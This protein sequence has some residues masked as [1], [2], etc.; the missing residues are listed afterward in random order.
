[1]Y[2]YRYIYTYTRYFHIETKIQNALCTNAQSFW[3]INEKPCHLQVSDQGWKIRREGEKGGI[4]PFLFSLL[5]PPFPLHPPLPSICWCQGGVPR[6]YLWRTLVLYTLLCKHHLLHAANL[7][8]SAALD[9]LSDL[10]FLFASLSFSFLLLLLLPYYFSFSFPS[11]SFFLLFLFISR[12]YQQ[13]SWHSFS[14]C[15]PF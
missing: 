5:S 6:A 4:L 9:F 10:P 13:N 1:M 8:L 3:V 15:V 2:L 7:P 14:L 11:S 12:L